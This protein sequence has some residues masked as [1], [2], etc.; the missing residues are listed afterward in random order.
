MEP[1][2]IGPS[3]ELVVEDAVRLAWLARLFGRGIAQYVRLVVRTAR[4][5]GDPINQ[6]QVI[7]AVWHESNLAVAV[8]AVRL[9]QDARIV[10]FS[11]RRFRGV[12]MNTML[13]ALDGGAVTLPDPGA[14][15]RAEAASVARAMAAVGRSGRSL[16]VSCDGPEGPYRVA[17]PGVL[18]VARESGLPV[19]PLALASRPLLRLTR[20][21]DRMLLPLPFGRIR[22]EQGRILRV[23]PRQ[24]IKPVLAE[25]QAEL[26]RLATLADRR[27]ATTAKT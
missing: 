25:L 15:S 16:M 12:V 5:S 10:S 18:I 1:A 14:R 24:R 9:R 4:F 26:D 22:L 19:Q 17:K 7:F 13:D 8:A 6:G 11:T 2:P 27:T 23:A 21:W 3:R 20:R